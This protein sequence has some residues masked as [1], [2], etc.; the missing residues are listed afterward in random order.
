[1]PYPRPKGYPGYGE[2]AHMI[3][4]SPMGPFEYA[5][6]ILKNPI[7]FFGDGGNLH[8]CIFNF[9]NQW[10]ITYHTQTLA[11]AHNRAKGFRSPHI[12]RLEFYG[13]GRI[14][15]VAANREGVVLDGTI[16]PYILNYANTFAWCCGVNTAE[17]EQGNHL[18]EIHNGDWIAIANVDFGQK[19]ATHFIAY[20]SSFVG[21]EIE[22]RLDNPYGEYLGSVAVGTTGTFSRWEERS[23]E[24]KPI[25]GVHH[26]FLTFRGDCETN[27]FDLKC[28]SF[29][30]FV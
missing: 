16:N 13:N 8:H 29:K 30:P 10:F 18:T 26:L 21:G 4:S 6:V 19:G 17:D 3:S 15:P 24:V 28:W 25:S 20:I 9:Q 2:I 22:I 11:R 27:L 7:T 14:K 23:C 1:V 12:N 5:G